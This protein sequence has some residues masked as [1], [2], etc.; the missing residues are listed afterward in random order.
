LSR[1]AYLTT[2]ITCGIWTKLYFYVWSFD[3]LKIV[4]LI[5]TVVLKITVL[6]K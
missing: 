2:D 4:P 6:N 5:F 1:K 3:V